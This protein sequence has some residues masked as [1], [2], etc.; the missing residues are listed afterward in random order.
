MTP[1]SSNIESKSFM[2]SPA[3]FEYFLN[4]LRLSRIKVNIG[5]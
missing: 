2:E 3:Q 4:Y 5:I 1:E